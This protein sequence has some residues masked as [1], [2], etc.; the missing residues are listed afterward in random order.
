[1]AERDGG[2]TYGL[3]VRV[4]LDP[5]ALPTFRRK[6]NYRA[7]HFVSQPVLSLAYPCYMISCNFNGLVVHTARECSPLVFPVYT[8][9]VIDKELFL[10]VQAKL[11]D[12]AVDRRV[13]RSR[14]PSFLSGLI[15]DDRDRYPRSRFPG[16]RQA[17]RP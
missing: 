17:S 6:V 14:S 8:E 7:T 3:A 11:Q 2:A 16:P 5:A 1:M 13:R 4:T 15:Y 10:A 12:R 9:H